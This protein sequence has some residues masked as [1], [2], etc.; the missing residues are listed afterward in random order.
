MPTRRRV[1][2]RCGASQSAAGSPSSNGPRTTDRASC[3]IRHA[4]GLRKVLGGGQRTVEL[5]HVHRRHLEIEAVSAR[6]G[7]H[8]L[9]VRDPRQHRPQE[10]HGHLDRRRRVGRMLLAPQRVDEHVL[11]DDLPAGQRK[12]L[13][14]ARPTSSTGSPRT[15]RCHARTAPRAGQGLGSPRAPAQHNDACIGPP[16][17]RTGTAS[18]SRGYSPRR[19]RTR[20]LHRRTWA[21]PP[22]RSIHRRIATPC[23]GNSSVSSHEALDRAEQPDVRAVVLT[24]TPPVFCAGADLKERATGG[25]DA[26]SAGNPMADA[27][28]A[29]GLDARRHDRRGRRTGPRR[30]HR[31][32]GRV[33][34]RGG[35]PRRHVRTHRGAHRCRPGDHQRADPGPLRVEQAGGAVPH[36]RTVRRRPPHGTWGWSRTSPTTWPAPCRPSCAGVLAGAPDAVAAAKRLLRRG[37]AGHAGDDR[38]QRPLFDGAEARR[39]HARLRREAAAVVGASRHRERETDHDRA[40]RS[41]RSRR[42]RRS[43]PTASRCSARSPRTT[44]SSRS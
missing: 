14:H 30:R 32:D 13:E 10:R 15:S 20:A 21:W 6:L 27:I 33:R 8:D 28:D 44:N 34:P 37:P 18:T 31:A 40:A 1:R 36:R 12:D 26:Q 17:H 7:D 19:G 9:N 2:S 4:L 25:A 16:G 38:T 24:H 11:G 3:R 5:H 22:S 42:A 29:V 39:G 35:E 41:G 43:S 23:R